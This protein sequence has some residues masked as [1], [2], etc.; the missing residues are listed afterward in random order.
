[1]GQVG[2]KKQDCYVEDDEGRAWTEKRNRAKFRGAPSK[3]G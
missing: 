2:E 3:V 1:M